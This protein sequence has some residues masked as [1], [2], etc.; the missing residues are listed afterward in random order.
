MS[1]CGLLQGRKH[2]DIQTD[3]CAK[4]STAVTGPSPLSSFLKRASYERNII[5]IRS[6]QDALRSFLVL[7]TKKCKHYDHCLYQVLGEANWSHCRVWGMVSLTAKS[8][9]KAETVEKGN[10]LNLHKSRTGSSMVKKDEIQEL[11]TW[12]SLQVGHILSV[13]LVTDRN[14]I[15]H[16]SRF[17]RY[18][19]SFTCLSRKI[20]SLW[21]GRNADRLHPGPSALTAL[22]ASEGMRT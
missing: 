3:T 22:H 19:R 11:F 5:C 8:Q 10:P 7:V 9:A 18:S 2:M 15:T 12:Y 13:L 17:C 6:Q 21:P 20:V 16:F 4:G 14:I 1:L